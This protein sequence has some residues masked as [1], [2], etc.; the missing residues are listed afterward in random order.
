MNEE[1]GSE[2]MEAVNTGSLSNEEREEQAEALKAQGNDDLKNGHLAAAIR[3][4]SEAI[5]IYP[6]AIYYSNRAMAYIKAESFGLALADA[7]TA[8][9]LDPT[10]IKAR[11]RR[12][13]ANFALLKYRDALKDFRV[14]LKLKPKDK[15]ARR[16]Y[17]IC[18]KAVKEAAFAEAIQHESTIPL[19]ETLTIED[20]AVESSYEGLVWEDDAPLSVEFVD[21]MIERFRSQQTIHRKYALRLVKEALS[22]FQQE[23]NCLDIHVST[24]Q[25][26][27]GEEEVGDVIACGDTHGQF[28][29]VLHIFEMIQFPHHINDKESGTIR[30]SYI[31][32]G[33]FVDRG[34]FSCEV[35]LLYYALK[36]LFPTAFYLVRG[37]HE[38]INMN[39][40]YGFYDE[41]VT[42]YSETVYR[43]FMHSFQWLPLCATLN[44]QVF[45]VHGGLPSDP[46]TSIRTINSLPRERE[47]PPEGT[48][49]DLLW[50]DPHD[51]MGLIPSK[52]G[53][54][55]QF[56]FDITST[57]FQF[58][59]NPQTSQST[60]RD[61]GAYDLS[62]LVRSHEMKEPGFEWSQNNQT[63]TLFSS[64]NYCDQMGNFGAF[65][66]FSLASG[67]EEEGGEEEDK[68]LNYD[69][70]D[71]KE[72]HTNIMTFWHAK[73]G[74]VPGALNNDTSP[75]LST[76]PSPR[77][78]RKK[79]TDNEGS[80]QSAPL[81][82]QLY[83]FAC[84]EHPDI[85]CMAYSKF[86]GMV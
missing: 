66:R 69:F 77:V 11:Y 74:M 6:T 82:C 55:F 1:K 58:N 80:S 10:Y 13:S 26:E 2:E 23:P 65:L 14:V 54:G 86:G 42:K 79:S 68:R 9:A 70:E 46:R 75:P 16:K 73:N 51:N 71:E 5:D 21:D 60:T 84:S 83:P 63:L 20:I 78:L 8:I 35:I 85:A 15:D 33:D 24:F 57:F 3:H 28:Y 4:Y 44:N 19:Y 30:R 41:A 25:N 62:L 22:L 12:G 48:M 43:M 47:P 64:P 53:V 52:R 39:K 36:V 34:S 72:R 61:G 27:Q 17:K 29:D 45:F 81:H 50:S 40:M 76:F 7:N 37:N 59:N 56:G 67:D 31:F 38:T 18:D 49:S 32:N